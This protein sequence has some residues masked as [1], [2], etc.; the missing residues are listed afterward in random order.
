M[1]QC[2]KAALISE[3]QAI[4]HAL[5]IINSQPDVEFGEIKPIDSEKENDGL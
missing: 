5:E 2:K 3:S 4:I 1:S